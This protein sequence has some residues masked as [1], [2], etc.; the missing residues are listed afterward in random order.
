MADDD[1]I[2]RRGITLWEDGT[3]R[4]LAEIEDD[5]PLGM[6]DEVAR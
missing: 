5:R 3:Q 4:T 6:L 2:E 1:G